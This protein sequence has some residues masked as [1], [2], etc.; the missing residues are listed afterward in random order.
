VRNR[1]YEFHRDESHTVT[2]VFD[3]ETGRWHVE[4][5]GPRIR[6]TRFPLTAFEKSEDG[7]RHLA[8]LQD[9]ISRAALDA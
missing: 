4:V 6:Q 9:A 5:W 3:T 8:A 2:L 7:R 1:R